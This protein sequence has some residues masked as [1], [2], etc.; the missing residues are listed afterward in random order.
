MITPKNTPLSF[1]TKFDGKVAHGPWKKPLDFGGDL[2]HIMLVLGLG[3]RL[4]GTEQF[5]GISSLGGGMRSTECHSS[6]YAPAPR[7]GGIK[8]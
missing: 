7:V 5:C 1:F 8:R 2:D 3:L 6:Y 4:G